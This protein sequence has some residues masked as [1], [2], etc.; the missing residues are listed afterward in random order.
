MN[1]SFIYKNFICHKAIYETFM[2][3]NDNHQMTK[4][5]YIT[6]PTGMFTNSFRIVMESGVKLSIAHPLDTGG[7]LETVLINNDDSIDHL[8]LL[9]HNNREELIN[10][11]LEL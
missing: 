11:I 3:L 4:H 6:V 8:S 1:D 9:H 5:K 2:C 10:Y 7:E